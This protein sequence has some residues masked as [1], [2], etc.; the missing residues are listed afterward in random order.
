MVRIADPA[1]TDHAFTLLRDLLRIASVNP[2]GDEARAAELVAGE[3]REAGLEPQVLVS[4]EGRANVVAIVSRT[5]RS[6]W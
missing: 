5:L 4:R 2:P 1:L 3:L 6:L